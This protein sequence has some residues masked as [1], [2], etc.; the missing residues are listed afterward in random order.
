ML[1]K[2]P[3]LEVMSKK[4]GAMLR[5]AR[6]Q[7]KESSETCAE[8]LNLTPQEYETIEYGEQ[9]PTLPQLELL[10]Y[11]L[12]KPIEP[13]LKQ[14]QVN[15]KDE[16]EPL[17][18][19]AAF[20][21]LRQR[22]IGAVLRK[23]RLE[24][25]FSLEEAAQSCQIPC[26]NMEAYELG[27]EPIPLPLLEVLALKLGIDFHEL[28]DQKGIIARKKKKDELFK[29]FSALPADLQTFV[30]AVENLP[31]LQAAQRLKQ[32]PLEHIQLLSESINKLLDVSIRQ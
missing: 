19:H 6:L 22:Y 15:N 21:D 28:R 1:E 13:F 27:E 23:A 9:A 3:K 26:S 32:M 10:T 11:H 12:N 31:Y 24:A 4:I 2:N 8:L 17:T 5:E 18:N 7:S 20:L 14:Y 16:L 25:H 30:A 29:S